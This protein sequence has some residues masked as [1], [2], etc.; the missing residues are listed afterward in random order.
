[1]DVKFRVFLASILIAFTA[2]KGGGNRMAIGHDLNGK[3]SATA[4]AADPDILKAVQANPQCLQLDALLHVVTGKNLEMNLYLSNHDVGALTGSGSS[5]GQVVTSLSDEKTRAQSVLPQ[6]TVLVQ[7]LNGGELGD[8]TNTLLGELLNITTQDGCKA[9][10]FGDKSV[11]TV[12]PASAPAPQ[13]Q[14]VGKKTVVV[15]TGQGQLVLIN[16]TNKADIRTYRVNN[17]GTRLEI[18]VQTPAAVGGT[19]EKDIVMT[20]G[21]ISDPLRVKY[22][23]ATLLHDAVLT[24]P[25]DLNKQIASTQSTK[26]ATADQMLTLQYQTMLLIQNSL[27]QKQI[28]TL[29]KP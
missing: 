24:P 27:T 4:A 11:Y 6:G 5:S 16:S 22:K 3:A 28:T 2:C 19:E 23:F 14:T 1:M 17:A 20:L 7:T 13:N 18:H 8:G 25:Q 12:D 26:T 15:A 10:T 29:L 21:S 9:V